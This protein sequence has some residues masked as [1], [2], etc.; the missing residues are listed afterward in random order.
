MSKRASNRDRNGLGR[1]AKAGQPS[2]VSARFGLGFL[3]GC[4][5]RDSLL[6]CT[7]MWG[8]DVVFLHG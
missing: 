2:P 7:C 1:S 8:F 6:V 3:P 5:S 4:F